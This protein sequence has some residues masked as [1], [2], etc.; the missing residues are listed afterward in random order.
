MSGR[1]ETKYQSTKDKKLG[2]RRR[3]SSFSS[4]HSY[5][6]SW[7]AWSRRMNGCRY[8]GAYP[9]SIQRVCHVI[10]SVLWLLVTYRDLRGWQRPKCSKSIAILRKQSTGLWTTKRRP[11]E[12]K[13]LIPCWRDMSMKEGK[14]LLWVTR[15]P[16]SDS[17]K[18]AGE[19]YLLL[20]HI[21][22]VKILR[23]AG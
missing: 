4:F 3:S 15:S 17:E 23:N 12:L 10:V 18:E 21:V 1:Y 5:T 19:K 14:Y 9:L 13:A 20:G 6:L 22:L 16:G 8:M 2:G 7:G 11:Y